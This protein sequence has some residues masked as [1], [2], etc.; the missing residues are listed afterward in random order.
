MSKIEFSA[1]QKAVLCQQL[2][3]YV[4]NELDHEIGQFESEFL[5]DFIAGTIGPHFYNQGVSDA[6]AVVAS[7]FEDIAHALYEIEVPL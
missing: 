7:R 2:K 4:A 3:A 6:A 1:E 5:L